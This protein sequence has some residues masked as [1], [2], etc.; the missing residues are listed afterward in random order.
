MNSV[1]TL[2]GLAIYSPHAR[3]VESKERTKEVE[4]A[5]GVWD[6]QSL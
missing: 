5:F 2:H 4:I 1:N 3:K 6:T